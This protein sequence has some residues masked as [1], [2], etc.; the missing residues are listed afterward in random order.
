MLQHIKLIMVVPLWPLV[1]LPASSLAAFAHAAEPIAPATARPDSS[2]AMLYYDVRPLGVEGQGWS[3]VAAPFSRLP[4]KAKTMVRP[5]IWELGTC[6]TGL[7]VRFTTDASAISA[8]WNLASPRL[9]MEHMPA[10]GVSG[11]DLYVKTDEGHWRFLG[12]GYPDRQA[13]SAELASDLPPGTR[14]YMLYLPLYN[15]VSS[16][17]IG[18][19]RGATIRRAEPRP[20]DRAK[21][22]V[23]YGTSIM[24][25]GCA[26]RPGMALTA[27]IGRRLDR[28]VINLG[29]TSNGT[30]DAEMATLLSELDAAVFVIDCLPNMTPEMV[31]DRAPTL[32]KT[33]RA[34]RPNTPIL[35]VEDPRLA[36]AFT[37]PSQRAG[38]LARRAA[39]HKTYEVCLAAGDRNIAL[40]QGDRLLATDGEDTVDGS[41]PTDLG[42]VHYA[43]AYQ[44]VLERLLQPK[45]AP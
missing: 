21:P 37:S 14:Q 39:L 45:L 36:K 17:E 32:V 30:M 1:V 2:G 29:F 5:R 7:V 6:S 12:V 42:F 35:L 11:V 27:M 31:A 40:L 25:G 33:I 38:H 20:A 16:V 15:G 13:M 43:N 18:V 10:T 22:I 19:P 34:A 26:S 41:H 44:P 8:R 9:A 23:F 28:P 4:S 3:D 24:Q